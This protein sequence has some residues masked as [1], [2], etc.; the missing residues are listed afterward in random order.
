MGIIQTSKK[1]KIQG[2]V[3]RREMQVL[4][5]LVKGYENDYIQKKMDITYDTLKTHRLSIFKKLKVENAVQ[6]THLAL[7]QDLIGQPPANREIVCVGVNR[8]QRT[9]LL[10]L[11]RRN[12]V[13]IRQ[14]CED[15]IAGFANNKY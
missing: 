7:R 1:K 3:S 6:L 11:A 12:K 5:L 14:Y 2:L 4:L 13:T 8:R 9:K 10:R 15:L